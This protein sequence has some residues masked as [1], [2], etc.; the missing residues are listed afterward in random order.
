MLAGERYD[1]NARELVADRDPIGLTV[2][3]HVASRTRVQ[4][5]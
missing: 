1:A 4:R 2:P 3:S 5:I